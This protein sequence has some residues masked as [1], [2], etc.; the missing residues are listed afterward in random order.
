MRLT[1]S[2]GKP[3]GFSIQNRRNPFFLYLPFNAPHSASTFSKNEQEVPERYRAMYGGGLDWATQ[4][5]GL[6]THLDDAV[7]QILSHLKQEIDRDN[8][9]VLFTS[10][11]GGSGQRVR[12]G[13]CGAVKRRCSKAVFAFR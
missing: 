4:Y 10:D 11:N 8:T 2:C 1:C 13:R 6:I 5:R 7:G 3:S 9:L 12:T